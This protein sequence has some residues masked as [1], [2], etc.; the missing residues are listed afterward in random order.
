MIQPD[1][2]PSGP[3]SCGHADVRVERLKSEGPTESEVADAREALM[4]AY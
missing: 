2:I 4:V 3:R 1:A